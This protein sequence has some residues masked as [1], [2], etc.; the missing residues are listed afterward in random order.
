[1]A[2]RSTRNCESA[3]GIRGARQNHN[4]LAVSGIAP[5]IVEHDIHRAIN[6]IHR[7][8]LK[9]LLGAIVHGI[10]VHPRGRSP[11]FAAIRGTGR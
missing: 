8:P 3:P 5:A 11:M 6:R 2:P 10:I 9:E 4:L 1:M 7:Q